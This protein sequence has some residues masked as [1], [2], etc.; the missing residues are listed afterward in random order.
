MGAGRP[1]SYKAEYAKQAGKL[2]SLG[3]TDIEI[4]AA[5]SIQPRIVFNPHPVRRQKTTTAAA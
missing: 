3:A 1:K 2:C 4:A 5:S